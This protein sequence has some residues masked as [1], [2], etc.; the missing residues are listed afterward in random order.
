M[1]VT[2]KPLTPETIEACTK[3]IEEAMELVHL[4]SFSITS[5]NFPLFRKLRSSEEKV[6]HYSFFVDPRQCIMVEFTIDEERGCEGTWHRYWNLT[7]HGI[8]TWETVVEAERADWEDPTALSMQ[9][10]DHTNPRRGS[11]NRCPLE[12]GDLQVLS[13]KFQAA[14]WRRE[15]APTTYAE[16]GAWAKNIL[17]KTN[18]RKYALPGPLPHLRGL[19]VGPEAFHVYDGCSDAFWR[20]YPIEKLLSFSKKTVCRAEYE[21]EVAYSLRPETQKFYRDLGMGKV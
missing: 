3:A 2:P 10:P 19:V 1:I 15:E 14:S 7:L 17:G 16:L 4:G 11:G 13:V 20:A 12:K 9:A 6:S 21:R 5:R 8:V 18:L